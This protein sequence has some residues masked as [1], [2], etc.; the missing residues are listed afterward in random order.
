MIKQ[1]EFTMENV[2]QI[3]EIEKQ[4]FK[5]SAWN[6]H[7]VQGEF[8]NKY[9][10]FFGDVEEDGTING[11]VSLRIMYEEAQ[12]CN[13]AVLPNKRRNGVGTALVNCAIAFAKQQ[14]CKY[15]ELEV[16]VCNSG[17]K[18]LYE[19][20]GFAVEG[21]RKNFYR[22]CDYD[23]KDAYTMTCSLVEEDEPIGAFTD[24]D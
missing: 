5:G 3:V 23:S 18:G 12:F 8:N 17:A 11:Y 14:N 15:A 24:G 2:F 10:Y 1:L 7:A 6:I 9:S 21:V 22:H 20:C 16:N 19:K 13:V 4:C